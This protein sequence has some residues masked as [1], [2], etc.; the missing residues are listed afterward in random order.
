MLLRDIASDAAS[1]MSARER[2]RSGLLIARTLLGGWKFLLF[3]L[4]LR[5][6]RFR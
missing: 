4:R 1:A 6:F 3:L 2:M 5:L